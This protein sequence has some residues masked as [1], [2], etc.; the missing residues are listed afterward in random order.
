MNFNK[1]LVILHNKHGIQN[2]ST[3]ITSDFQQKKEH[4]LELHELK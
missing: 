3:W 2:G 1:V 4:E